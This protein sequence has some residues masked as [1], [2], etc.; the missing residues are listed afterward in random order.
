[1]NSLASMSV[2]Y[3]EEQNGNNMPVCKNIGEMEKLRLPTPTVLMLVSYQNH[4]NSK[5]GGVMEMGMT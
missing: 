1:M 4:Y 5:E 2:N 3:Q